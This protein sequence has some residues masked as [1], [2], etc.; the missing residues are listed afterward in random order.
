MP[1]R[2]TE[3]CAGEYYHFYNRGHN[4]ERIFY[5]HDNYL[6]FLG[7]HRE[8]LVPVLDVVAYCLMPTCYHSLDRVKEKCDLDR[9]TQHDS[10]RACEGSAIL[11]SVPDGKAN[12]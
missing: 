10:Q 3:L 6:F 1:R 8:Y 7:R 5:E 11:R 9:R 12:D 4:R 2:N